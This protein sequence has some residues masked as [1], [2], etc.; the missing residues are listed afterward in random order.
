MNSAHIAQPKQPTTN[1]HVC[2]DLSSDSSSDIDMNSAHI[3]QPKQPTT[4]VH[5][6]EDLSSDSSSDIDMN[7]AHIPQPEQ[8]TTNVHIPKSSD[9]SSDPDFAKSAFQNYGNDNGCQQ[10]QH[11]KRHTRSKQ[12]NLVEDLLQ[13]QIVIMSNIDNQFSSDESW[14]DVDSNQLESNPLNPWGDMNVE[15]MGQIQILATHHMTFYELKTKWTFKM[16]NTQIL[17]QHQIPLQTKIVH[18]Q[19][20]MIQFQSHA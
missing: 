9:S 5:V 10:S 20:L 14:V 2:E 15:N 8:P 18:H 7:S 4:N 1:V 13:S 6:C 16:I 11:Y 3:A 19:N 12:E 17:T